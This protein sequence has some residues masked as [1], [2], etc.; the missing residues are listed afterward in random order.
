MVRE[1][2]R[3]RTLRSESVRPS[4]LKPS[5]W[6]ASLSLV[7]ASFFCFVVFFEVWGI[8]PIQWCPDAN[9]GVELKSASP[10]STQSQAGLLPGDR[11]VAAGDQPIRNALD[12][13][14][15]LSFFRPGHPVELAIERQG[16]SFR[17]TVMPR[18][19]GPWSIDT[20]GLLIVLSFR[21]PAIVIAILLVWA[22]PREP[23]VL[24]GAWLM[25]TLATIID[26]PRPGM[27]AVWQ[28][29]PGLV[30]TLMWIP[31]V[32]G[33]VLAGAILF[34]FAATLS[35]RTRRYPRAYLLVW[36]P[37]LFALA[38]VSPMFARIAS[39]ERTESGDLQRL[40]GLM[41]VSVLYVAGALTVLVFGYRR[42]TDL[43]ER[44]RV[45]VIVLGA[46]LAFL[47]PLPVLV[48]QAISYSPTRPLS[49]IAQLTG[50]LAVAFPLSF[51]YA[52]LR[53][54][55][56]DIRMI[57]RAGVRYALA[58]RML[59]SIVPVL[60]ALFVLDLLQHGS[61][62][63]L[64]VIAERGWLYAGLGVLALFAH[65]R[66][67]QWLNALDRRFFRE[68]FDTLLSLRNLTDE[69]RR[70]SLALSAWPDVVT[71]V[72]SALH[73]DFA[74]L[75]LAGRGETLLRPA[76]VAP[77]DRQLPPWPAGSR[78]LALLKLIDAPL[79]VGSESNS[80][81]PRR[82]SRR[83]IRL[84]SGKPP[85]T[86]NPNRIAPRRGF[87]GARPEGLPGSVRS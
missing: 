42:I 31:F 15:A 11:I 23:R 76:A 25:G 55:L 57:V 44:R 28:A 63:L 64:S 27:A 37:A 34:T 81:T 18:R 17:A 43:N 73:A 4:E 86:G 74:A 79:E 35:S 16:H 24:V 78:L 53:H 13:T 29:L 22:R 66:R 14:I 71:T 33:L 26:A 82:S 41:P 52:L 9:G 21:V 61:R 32:S 67:D 62:P 50:L 51:G 45:R 59:L 68:K 75:M 54:R 36:I 1:T 7:Y 20:R 58:R 30:S 77:S 5:W 49:L 40:V 85:R 70:S 87:P 47:A 84:D 83:G 72:G 56:F 65:G 38:W 39:T 48:A 69:I 80:R 60:G 19:A 10:N 46:V 12:W 3:S 6:V 8:D 2:P